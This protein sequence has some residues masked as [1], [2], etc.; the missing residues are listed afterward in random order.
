MRLGNARTDEDLLA[1][2]IGKSYQ[3]VKYLYSTGYIGQVAFEAY[4]W[5][6]ANSRTSYYSLNYNFVGKSVPS[7]AEHLVQPYL[8]YVYVLTVQ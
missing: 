7:G 2:I 4:C 1:E 3:Q 6:W 5:L 8:R